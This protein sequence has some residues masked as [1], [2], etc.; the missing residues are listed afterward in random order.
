MQASDEVGETV[1]FSEEGD[2]RVRVVLL[3]GVIVSLLMYTIS[4]PGRDAIR[5]LC[6]AC[7]VKRGLKSR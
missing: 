7:K 4:R 2:D 5:F 6:K 3:G 1:R